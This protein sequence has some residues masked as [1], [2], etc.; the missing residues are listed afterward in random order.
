MSVF[1]VALGQIAPYYNL[2]FVAISVYLFIQLFRTHAVRKSRAYI[3]PWV[4]LFIAVCIFIIEELFTVLRS[5]GVLNFPA[6]INGFFELVII[7]LFI[8]CLLLQREHIKKHH[9]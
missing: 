5:V 9:K 1:T 8:Y 4:F 6:H 2:G 7:A 3:T